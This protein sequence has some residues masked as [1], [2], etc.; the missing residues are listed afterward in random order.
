MSPAAH[1]VPVQWQT[2]SLSPLSVV[3]Y[4]DTHE[5]GELQSSGGADGGDGSDGGDGD[6]GGG[7]HIITEPAT[8]WTPVEWQSLKPL[9]TLGWLL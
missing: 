7:A 1:S 3:V 5:L 4:E 8:H 9:T 2:R 6:G